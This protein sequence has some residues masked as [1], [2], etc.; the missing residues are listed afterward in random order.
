MSS[1]GEWTQI[2]QNGSHPYSVQLT[3]CS[4]LL[5]LLQPQE[6]RTVVL[7]GR[8]RIEGGR[9]G[10]GGVNAGLLASLCSGQVLHLPRLHRDELG[11]LLFLES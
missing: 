1:F 6:A 10:R 9:G 3:E 5:A 2:K 4:V 7:V 11:R 8:N